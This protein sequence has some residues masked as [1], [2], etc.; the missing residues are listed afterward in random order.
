MNELVKNG[1]GWQK[2]QE[3]WQMKKELFSLLAAIQKCLAMKG[4][5]L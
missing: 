4:K 5:E 3:E 2:F 1:H